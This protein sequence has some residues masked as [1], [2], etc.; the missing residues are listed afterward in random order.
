MTSASLLPEIIMIRN[1]TRKFAGA[2]ML[3]FF[4]MGCSTQKVTISPL[5]DFIG[6]YENVEREHGY[7]PFVELRSGEKVYGKKLSFGAEVLGKRRNTI[8]LDKIV[9]EHREVKSA[10]DGYCFYRPTEEGFAKRIIKGKLNIYLLYYSQNFYF[11]QRGDEE[12]L[13]SLNRVGQLRE[14]L[15]DCPLAL[16]IFDEGNANILQ[17]KRQNNHFMSTAIYRFNNNCSE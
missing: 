11:I 17:S 12:K 5:H 7:A 4:F 6:T 3:L 16:E 10:F 2:V 13:L 15:E 9:Y 8:K 14:Y 1:S